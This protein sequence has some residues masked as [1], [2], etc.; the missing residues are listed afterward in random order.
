MENVR[1]SVLG[2]AVGPSEEAL[3]GLMLVPATAGIE[4]FMGRSSL[5]QAGSSPAG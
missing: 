4:E 1:L 3:R 5:L 2:R